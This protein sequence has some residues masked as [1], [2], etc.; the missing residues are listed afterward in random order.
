MEGKNLTI[1][2]IAKAAGV[3]KTTVSRYLNGRFDLINPETKHRIQSIIELTGYRPNATAR[4]LKSLH[5]MM[6]G[7]IVADISSPFSAALIVGI[8]DVL[9]KAGYQPLFVNCNESLENEKELIASLTARGVDGLLVNTVSYNNP[10][11]I[12][13]ACKGMPIV[14]C[15]RQ[16]KDYNFDIATTN[17]NDLFPQVMEHIKEQGF[18]PPVLFT[19]AYQNNFTRLSRISGFCNSLSKTYDIKNPDD[20]VI[21]IDVNNGLDTQKKLLKLRSSYSADQ[22]PCVIG[23]NTLTTMNLLTQIK[24]LNLDIPY[25]IGICG[26]DDWSWKRYIDIAQIVSPGISGMLIHSAELGKQ[27]ASLLLARLQNP[28]KPKQVITIPSEFVIRNST[29]LKK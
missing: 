19:Q 2:D 27:A 20:Y 25:D 21:Q 13:L 23:V 12:E 29:I 8:S 10:Y 1:K 16:V 15:D 3:S 28:D 24:A 14:L 6:I 4:H 11:L 7:V 26:P 9:D 5:S 17:L 18:Q 22:I